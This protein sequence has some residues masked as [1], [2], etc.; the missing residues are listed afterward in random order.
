[1]KNILKV[2][3]SYVLFLFFTFFLTTIIPLLLYSMVQTL[4]QLLFLDKLSFSNKIWGYIW[5]N[6]SVL[7]GLC[8]FYYTI[9]VLN[10]NFSD[11]PIGSFIVF[12]ALGITLFLCPFNDTF[13]SIIAF[14]FSECRWIG[15]DSVLNIYA[16]IG[17][18]LFLY[19]I[20]IYHKE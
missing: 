17:I 14:Y 12:M 16:Y 2:I 19:S 20:N 5:I 9:T 3:F 15:A 4:Q 7:T 13:S 11:Y 1:M 6:A 18:I 8:G 10:K